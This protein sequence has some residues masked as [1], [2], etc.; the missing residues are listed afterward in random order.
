MEDSNNLSK[1]QMCLLHFKIFKRFMLSSESWLFL[2]LIGFSLSYPLEIYSERSLTDDLQKK[3]QEQQSLV[4]KH[5]ADL[6]SCRSLC[7]NQCRMRCSSQE[8]CECSSSSCDAEDCSTAKANYNNSKNTLERFKTQLAGYQEWE[9]EPPSQT[10]E[11][12]DSKPQNFETNTQVSQN[13]EEKSLL[14]KIQNKR[15]NMKRNTM[16]GAAASAG[17]WWRAK[18]CCKTTSDCNPQCKMWVGAAA[19]ATAATGYMFGQTRAFKNTE[20]KMCTNPNAEGCS[21]SSPNN[22]NSPPNT[23]ND[24]PLVFPPSCA[25]T[26]GSCDQIIAAIKKAVNSTPDCPPG[27]TSCKTTP[28]NPN[29]LSTNSL[30]NDINKQL[31]RTF[32]PEEGWPEEALAEAQNFSFDNMTPEQ[33]REIDNALLE[34]NNKNKSFGEPLKTTSLLGSPTSGHAATKSSE[35]TEEIAYEDSE[36]SESSGSTGGGTSATDSF[37]GGEGDQM[38][39]SHGGT[40]KPKRKKSNLADQMNQMLKKLYGD[41]SGKGKDPLAKQHIDFGADKVGVIE[42]NIF[43]M[44]HRS[45]RTLDEEQDIFL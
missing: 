13:T 43:M 10:H 27:D 38:V 40:K 35:D 15:K 9:T 21:D 17:L 37:T 24:S 30:D 2:F 41:K 28:P 22:S 33:K 18:T 7:V 36:D 25:E 8:T 26:P 16:I 32:Q 12:Q 31:L 39:A 45:H 44:I 29:L 1:I 5:S 11:E 3:I 23:Q 42:D 19:A 6:I 34:L 4:E 14:Q 20:K